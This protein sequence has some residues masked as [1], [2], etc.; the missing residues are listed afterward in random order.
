MSALLRCLQ[1]DYELADVPAQCPECGTVTLEGRELRVHARWARGV[2]LGLAAIF[3]VDAIVAAWYLYYAYDAVRE[4]YALSAGESGPPLILRPSAWT[5]WWQ[6]LPFATSVLGFLTAS[7]ILIVNRRMRR[8]PK[9]YI[10]WATM[11]LAAYLLAGRLVDM[12][13]LYVG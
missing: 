10:P 12:L 13:L 4:L 3:L 6:W 1:C 9:R 2:L 5:D 7:T 8:T 11:A